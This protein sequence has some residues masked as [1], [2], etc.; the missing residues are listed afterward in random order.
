MLKLEF[1]FVL[2]AEIIQVLDSISWVRC[3]LA[4]FFLFFF[5]RE[6]CEIPSKQ[7]LEISI[8]QIHTTA[9]GSKGMLRFSKAL[10]QVL[11]VLLAF[12]ILCSGMV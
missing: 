9:K 1:V 5:C 11:A 6:K 7:I 4:M 10:F 3:A 2:V 8:K 12:T